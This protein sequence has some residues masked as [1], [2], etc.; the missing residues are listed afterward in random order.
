MS[1]TFVASAAFS[2]AAWFEKRQRAEADAQ[3][4]R[5]AYADCT[6][7]IDA[8]AEDVVFPLE[9]FADGRVKS[10]VTLKRANFFPGT[11]FVWGEGVRAEQFREDGSLEVSVDAEN[12]LVDFGT[13]TGWVEGRAT[14]ASGD[15]LGQ[16]R[17]VYISWRS[18]EVFIKIFSESEIRARYSDMSI[19]SQFK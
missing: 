6:K 14:V 19:R 8:P 17:R 12:C 1:A 18:K 16:G 3:R 10:R 4:L 5:A 7:K 11:K 13:E 15:Y 2:S 9:S